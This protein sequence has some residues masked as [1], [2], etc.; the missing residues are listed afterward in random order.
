VSTFIGAF[1]ST[2]LPVHDVDVTETTGHLERFR[3]DVDFLANAGITRVR[4]AL[5]WHRTEVVP[6][7]FDWTS[8]DAQLTYLRDRGIEPIVDFVHHTSYPAWLS[9]GFRDRRFGPSFLAFVGAAASRYPWISS[10]TLFNEPFATLFLAG[11]EAL[12]P[13]YDRGIAGFTRLALN[14]M[15]ALSEASVLLESVLPNA[16]H[17]WIDTCESHSGS[18]DSGARYAELANDRRHV[19]L[20]LALGHDLDPERPFFRELVKA[21][22]GALLDLP[23]MRIDVI[24]LDYYCH[25]EWSY[26]IVGATSP[27]TTPVGFAALAQHYGDRYG[28]PMILAETNV[29]GLPSDRAS[30]LR[31]MLEQFEIAIS[32]GV[33]LIG[34]CWFPTIDSCDWDSLL[35]RPAGRVDP[36]GVVT[37]GPDLEREQTLFTRVW[38][39]AASGIPS[40]DLPAYR[41]QSPC[42]SQL[43]GLAPH[44]KH[45]PWQDP[46]ATEIVPPLTV[47]TE[48]ERIADDREF[49]A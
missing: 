28:L 24:G 3:S 18:D 12:W 17:V 14:V 6:G 44:L 15:P 13:P 5:R 16:Q 1:E 22:G 35:A 10:F 9:D 25:S 40:R 29:R 38:L 4:F 34:F 41:W 43:A 2:Y 27:S 46:P 30:W 8:T 36:V 37:V 49:V 19:L 21:G 32:N 20:D 31:Y 7:H 48:L 33:D 11:H 23:P 45:W 26:D 42:D 47:R 39:A